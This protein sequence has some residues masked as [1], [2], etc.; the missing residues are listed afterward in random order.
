MRA[1]LLDDLALALPHLLDEDSEVLASTLSGQLYRP[2]IVALLASI[3][4]RPPAPAT[5]RPLAEALEEGELLTE[6]I[7]L[8][9]ELRSAIATELAADPVTRHRVD[10]ELF[11]FLDQLAADREA[12]ARRRAMA[13]T[14]VLPASIIDDVARRE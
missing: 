12:S 5:G 2:Y 3:E 1:L 13:T 10:T 11:S 6:T 7:A 14:L 4:R 9:M 8:L